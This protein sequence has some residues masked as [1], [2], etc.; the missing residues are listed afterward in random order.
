MRTFSL[1]S[2]CAA[3]IAAAAC[4]STSS[5]SGGGE[6]RSEADV[7]RLFEPSCRI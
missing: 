6:I 4:S 1:V 7:Q 5:D 2:F 3:L